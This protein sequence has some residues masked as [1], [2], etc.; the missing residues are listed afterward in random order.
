MKRVTTPVMT[1]VFATTLFLCV[2]AL[3][4]AAQCTKIQSGAILS[5]T[6]ETVTTGFDKW[7]YNYQAH[8]FNGLSANFS[9]PTLPATEGTETLVM[10]WSD[11]W[12]AN[13]DCN[14]D[15]KLDRG[16]NPKTGDSTGASRGWVTNHYEGDYQ[17][18]GEFYHYTYFAKIVYDGGAACGAAED[19]CLWGLLHADRGGLQ[20]P[21][22]PRAHGN[23]RTKLVHPAGLGVAR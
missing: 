9:R 22:R 23:D 3:P 15:E 4:A 12:L 21:A 8:L 2:G 20:R 11:D 18:S 1:C 7:G 17:D 6:G 14:N 13:V 16:L 5:A 19:S 10:K